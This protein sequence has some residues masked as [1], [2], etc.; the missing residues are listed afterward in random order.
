MAEAVAAALLPVSRQDRNVVARVVASEGHVRAGEKYRSKTLMTFQHTMTG[1]DLL[2]MSL[3]LEEHGSCLEVT[4]ADSNGLYE[5]SY[6]GERAAVEQAVFEGLLSYAQGAGFTQVRLNQHD[7]SSDSSLF[8]LAPADSKWGHGEADATWERAVASCRQAG[9]VLGSMFDG[10]G[11]VAKLRASGEQVPEGTDTP[12]KVASGRDALLSLMASY[13]YRFDSL[14]TAKFSSMMI[15]YQL[16]KGWKKEGHHVSCNATTRRG[17]AVHD[18]DDD[19]EEEDEEEMEPTRPVTMPKLHQHHACAETHHHHHAKESS[20]HCEH[21]NSNN[22]KSASPQHVAQERLVSAAA[23]PPQHRNVHTRAQDQQQQHVAQEQYQNNNNNVQEEA[24]VARNYSNFNANMSFDS[25][26]R[27]VN[28][29]LENL[30]NNAASS[31]FDA[32]RNGSFDTLREAP[33]PIGMGGI[34]GGRS[35]KMASFD[36]ADMMP[37]NDWMSISLPRTSAAA[38]ES[39]RAAMEAGLLARS[40]SQ[41]SLSS[42]PGPFPKTASFDIDAF[43]SQCAATTSRESS[44]AP[45]GCLTGFGANGMDSYREDSSFWDSLM[46]GDQ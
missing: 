13:D 46:L 3:L 14:Q 25:M 17:N 22:N 38:A 10:R 32:A 18:S 19:L 21:N 8:Y 43:V 31:S 6:E 30:I 42:K 36:G 11:S 27:S 45:N 33:R 5:E 37:C 23:P 41:E 4:H 40:V 16:A 44:P 12:C 24:P 2:F 20:R 34:F 7:A 39:E 35:F 9:C 1:S 29:T 15:V 26:P 28:T